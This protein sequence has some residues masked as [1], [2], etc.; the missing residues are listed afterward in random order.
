MGWEGGLLGWAG[1]PMGPAWGWLCPWLC[2]RVG[3]WGGNGGGGWEGLEGP[4][5]CWS[6]RI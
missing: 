1:T 2:P 3:G 5:G 6:K 4:W